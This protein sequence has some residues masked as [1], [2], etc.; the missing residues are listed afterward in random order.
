MLFERD[1]WDRNSIPGNRYL[2]AMLLVPPDNKLLED[3]HNYL[4]DLSRLGRADLNSTQARSAAAM[5]SKRIEDRGIMTHK[6]DRGYW[7]GTFASVRGTKIKSRFNPRNHELPEEVARLMKRRYWDS[8]SP[9]SMQVGV[10]AWLWLLH[11]YDLPLAVRTQYSV[12]SSWITK[13][14]TQNT[15]VVNLDS[16]ELFWLMHPQKYSAPAIRVREVIGCDPKLF[17]WDLSVSLEVIHV[18]DPTR[19]HVIPSRTIGP[20]HIFRVYPG[21]EWLNGW[22]FQQTDNPMPII[23]YIFLQVKSPFTHEEMVLY[24]QEVDPPLPSGGTNQQLKERIVE[25]IIANDS[26]DEQQWYREQVA[27]TIE[28]NEDLYGRSL[29]LS[30]FSSPRAAG[31]PP[32]TTGP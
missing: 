13:A 29:S 18:C 11:Y 14:L 20:K 15:I 16:G 3:I 12:R 19:W 4:R 25:H 22:F 17:Q 2:R 30:P 31:V 7:R 28:E 24:C 23:K 27:I 6:P 5:H 8:P 26:P 9:E 10:S 21:I 32:T 1:K